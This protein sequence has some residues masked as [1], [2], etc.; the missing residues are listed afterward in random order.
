MC[1]L[2]RSPQSAYTSE[3]YRQNKRKF[4]NGDGNSMFLQNVGKFLP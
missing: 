3:D 1:S 2:K 4:R